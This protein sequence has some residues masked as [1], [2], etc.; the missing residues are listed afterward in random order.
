MSKPELEEGVLENEVESTETA[1]Q[2]TDRGFLDANDVVQVATVAVV[3][4]G[5]AATLEA[6]LLSGFFIGVAAMVAPKYL[7]KIGNVSRGKLTTIGYG[8]QAIELVFSAINLTR[9]PRRA[10]MLR[11]RSARK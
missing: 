9:R 6:T 1:E 4:I 11:S 8:V 5:C 3:G 2:K 7:P 10:S